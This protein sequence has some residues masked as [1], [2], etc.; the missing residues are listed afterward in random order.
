MR[1]CYTCL[2]IQNLKQPNRFFVRFEVLAAVTM[3]I[4]VFWDV[5]VYVKAID[6]SEMLAPTYQSIRHRFQD[7]RSLVCAEIWSCISRLIFQN[8]GRERVHPTLLNIPELS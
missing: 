4:T 2:Q 8:V 7:N 1:V 5:E 6:S 3:D